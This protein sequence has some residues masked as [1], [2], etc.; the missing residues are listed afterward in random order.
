[1][2]RILGIDIGT[3][4][5]AALI[6][7]TTER[8]LVKK[9]SQPNSADITSDEKAFRQQNCEKI[10]LSLQKATNELLESGQKKLDIDALSVTGQMHGCLVL[11]SDKNPVTPLITWQD[12]RT[13]DIAPSGSTWIEEF[14]SLLKKTTAEKLGMEP[15]AGYLGPTLYWLIKN[16]SLPHR[17]AYIT[18][19]D[20]WLYSVLTGNAAD[21]FCTDPSFAQSTGLYIPCSKKWNNNLISGLGVDPKMLPQVLEPASL[22]GKTANRNFPLKNGVPVYLGMGDNQ[23]S[24]LGS[25]RHQHDSILLNIGTGG[26]V[27]VVIDKFLDIE[28]LDTRVFTGNDFLLVGTSLSAGGAFA[29]LVKFV[30]RIGEETFNSSLEDSFLYEKIESIAASDTDLECLPT[31]FGTRTEPAMRGSFSNI[32]E[33]NF[34]LADISRAVLNGIAQELHHHYAQMNRRRKHLVG[35]GNALRR[36]RALR[37]QVERIFGQKTLIPITQEESCLGAALCAAVGAGACG[38][39]AETSRYIRYHNTDDY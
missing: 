39:F 30:K 11:D 14:K 27:S 19:I 7:D 15:A 5:I 26:Q 10:L 4:S 9:A 12:R 20:A 2:A 25:L 28:G 6:F 35:A 34:T 29:L 16:D 18:T 36:G 33:T 3:S 13:L 31:F 22:V 37:E 8:K 23:A 24:V 21:A 17:S 32:S 38:S 1:M